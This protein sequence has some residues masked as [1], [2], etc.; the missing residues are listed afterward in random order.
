MW[1][2]RV[3]GISGYLA[4]A[5]DGAK[6]DSWTHLAHEPGNDAVEGGALEVQRLAAP[7]DA[8]L[9]CGGARAAWV[10]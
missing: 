3:T 10:L 5:P 8:L 6:P 1:M 4:A 9:A 2:P 7:A